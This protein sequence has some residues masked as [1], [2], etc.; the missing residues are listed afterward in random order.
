MCDAVS[1]TPVRPPVRL[2]AGKVPAGLSTVPSDCVT[3][4]LPIPSGAAPRRR[5]AQQSP[6]NPSLQGSPPL[7]RSQH[8]GSGAKPSTGT[9]F[10]TRFW[11][12]DSLLGARAGCGTAR[13]APGQ[14]PA[15]LL[16]PPPPRPFLPAG[17][18]GCPGRVSRRRGRP[19]PVPFVPSPS[20]L[21]WEQDPRPPSVRAARQRPPAPAAAGRCK[22]HLR[23]RGA[24]PG[25][26]FSQRIR[27]AFLAP[28]WGRGEAGRERGKGGSAGLSP[29]ALRRRR[30]RGRLRAPARSA[31]RPRRPLPVRLE[32]RREEEEEEERERS[33]EE[34]EESGGRG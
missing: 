26:L 12:R 1:G 18:G 25:V 24:R 22:K 31:P 16:A 21:T 2:L 9:R 27:T 19:R 5:E 8:S 17:P 28:R 30:L 10:S 4:R 15:P 33:G 14:Q 13:S 34:E 7:Q 23:G 6:G 29:S 11:V 20:P 3:K 32:R